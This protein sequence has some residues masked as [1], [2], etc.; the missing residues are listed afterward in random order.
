MRYLYYSAIP[1]GI[2]TE[3]LMVKALKSKISKGFRSAVPIVFI[4]LFY[5][6]FDSAI[7]NAKGS[8]G[9]ETLN[10][11]G[12]DMVRT[13]LWIRDNTPSPS[14]SKFTGKRPDYGI[15]STWGFGHELTYIARRPAVANNFADVLQ[16]RGYP[17]SLRFFTS[18]SEQESYEIMSTHSARFV[19]VVAPDYYSAMAARMSGKRLP[20]YF[21]DTWEP[22]SKALREIVVFRLYFADGKDIGRFR[23]VYE[24]EQSYISERFKKNKVFE[25]VKGAKLKGIAAPGSKV[26]ARLPLVSNQ[27]RVFTYESSVMAGKDGIFE[28][29]LPYASSG[30]PYNVVAKE[31]YAIDVNGKTRRVK[32]TDE[33]VIGGREI[34]VR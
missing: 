5:P 26:S 31:D 13:M 22:T 17:D 4:V 25:F 2:M 3:F 24:S 9:E 29:T 33:M 34:Y 16:G 21:T 30:G 11:N 10:P 15:M 14:D 23:L 32:V 28:M 6:T 20:G 7:Q 12:M 8:G 19:Y 1:I 27:G 18:V